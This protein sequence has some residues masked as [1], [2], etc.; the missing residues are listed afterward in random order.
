MASGE[1]KTKRLFEIALMDF[2]RVYFTTIISS[3][4]GRS[5]I[6]SSFSELGIENVAS[7]EDEIVES[8]SF[9]RD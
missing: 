1:A 5:Q 7:Q 2:S 6:E 9:F 4:L 3:W 8:K